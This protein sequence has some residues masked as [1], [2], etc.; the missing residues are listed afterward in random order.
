[1][2]WL[3][4]LLILLVLLVLGFFAWSWFD[5]PIRAKRD[6]VAFAK[7]MESCTPLDQTYREV[8]GRTRMHRAVIGP[9]D[10]ACEVV[11]D[12][13]SPKVLRCA[14]PMEDLPA[15]ATAFASQANWIGMFGGTRL[16]I[17]TSST[18]PLYEAMNGP[19]CELVDP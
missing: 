5:G 16:N 18:D 19:A 11:M 15:I 7:S 1:M 17:D 6:I 9:K 2:I 13:T 10:G 12:T 4:R 14:F 8:I 3:R